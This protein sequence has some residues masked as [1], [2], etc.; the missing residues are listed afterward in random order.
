[1]RLRTGDSTEQDWQLLLSR[2][3]SLVANLNEFDDAIK[4][5]YGNDDVAA[6]NH[7]EPLNQ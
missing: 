7:Q 2:Q 5:F 4:L 1:M 3:P 6:Y